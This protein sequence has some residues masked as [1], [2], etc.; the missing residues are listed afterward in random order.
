LDTAERQLIAAD[1]MQIEW[2]V[3]S[4][5][6]TDMLKAIFKEFDLPISVVYAP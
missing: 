5:E 3:V 1:G 2:R 4:Q 6:G